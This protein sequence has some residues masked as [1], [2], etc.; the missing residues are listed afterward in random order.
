MTPAEA[1][2]TRPRWRTGWRTAGAAALLL[3]GLSQMLGD[4]FSVRWLKGIGAA[5]VAAPLPKVFSDVAGLETFASEFALEVESPR[6]VVRREIT[7]A[8]YARLRG[9]Y[10]RR[11]V[12]GAALSYAPRL[13]PALWQQVYC[14]AFASGGPLRRELEAPPDATAIRVHIATRT[15]GR[16]DR[17]TLEPICGR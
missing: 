11:N 15:R 8:L 3:L 4:V 6:G 16:G 10:N 1:A 14:Y 13:P 17:W 2:P 12:Y 5:S 7:P 9:P